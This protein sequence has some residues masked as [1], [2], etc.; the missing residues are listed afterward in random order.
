MEKAR[1]E[2]PGGIYEMC[3]IGIFVL[4]VIICGAVGGCSIEEGNRTK[5][6]DLSYPQ[7][8]RDLEQSGMAEFEGF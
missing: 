3:M 6:R 4:L 7:Y 5:V 1:R 2:I 8:L